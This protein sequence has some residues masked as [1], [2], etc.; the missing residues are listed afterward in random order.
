M[1]PSY[2][3]FYFS[4]FQVPFLFDPTRTRY[5]FSFSSLIS[6]AT[7][8]LEHPNFSI[9]SAVVICGSNCKISISFCDLLFIVS[10]IVSTDTDIVS[11]VNTTLAGS[12]NFVKNILRQRNLQ[13]FA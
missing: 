12:D 9:S 1:A 5:P 3:V 10:F 7:V 2:L 6:R 4:I 11:N 13:F 8:A